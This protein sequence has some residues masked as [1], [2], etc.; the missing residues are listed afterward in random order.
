M[1]YDKILRK[2]VHIFSTEIT[3]L[4]TAMQLAYRWAH[5]IISIITSAIQN[6]CKY[7]VWETNLGAFQKK[8]RKL[9]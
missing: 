4:G 6:E 7:M 5:T 2:N 1:K 3:W 8:S 9:C